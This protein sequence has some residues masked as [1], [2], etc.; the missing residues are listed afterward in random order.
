M[1][2][3]H[4][5]S[6]IPFFVKNKDKNFYIKDYEIL[7][8]FLSAMY[9]RKNNGSIKMY[10]DKKGANFIHKNGLA[11]IWDDGIN[12]TLLESNKHNIDRSVFWASCKIEALE[13][14]EVEEVVHLDTDFVFLEKIEKIKNGKSFITAHNEPIFPG[15]IYVDKEVLV[16]TP[17][18]I[19]D[20]LWDWSV[21]AFNMSFIYFKNK[22]TKEHIIREAFRFMKNNNKHRETMREKTQD[23][24]FAE[25]RI[26]AMVSA[27]KGIRTGFLEEV[28]N[29]NIGPEFN[30]EGVFR[31]T[32]GLKRI[33]N[34]DKSVEK[35][36][37]RN[38]IAEAKRVFPEY[39]YILESVN[40]LKKFF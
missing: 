11:D 39:I 28:E 16:T 3:L 12:V 31:H 18:Y 35:F 22:R 38:L 27:A 34:K 4:S 1:R 17:D 20:P 24:V 9:W 19:F 26:S 36:F 23:M 33:L 30:V 7:T 2:A 6:T 15:G 37:C 40:S 14:E 29:H 5:L 10:T 21:D 32:W 25:Q 13:N 8:M